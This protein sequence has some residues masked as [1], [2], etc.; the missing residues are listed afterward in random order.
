MGKI[1]LQKVLIGGLIAGVVLNVVDYVLYGVILKAQMDAAMQALNKPPIGAS[2][3][4]VFVALDFVVGV[5]LVWLYAAI[6]PRYGAGPATAVKAGLA[7]WFLGGLVQAAAMWPMAIMP[8]NL[9]V[10]STAVMLVEFP[11]ATLVGAKFYLE[12]ASLGAGMG[13]TAGMGSRM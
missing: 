10:I 9:T 11:L 4:G 1:N 5:F 6:R 7:A 8:H 13:A 12:G 3:I 2:A